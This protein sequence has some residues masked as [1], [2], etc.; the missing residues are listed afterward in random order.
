[1]AFILFIVFLALKLTKTIDWS[2]VWVTSP[3]WIS[4]ITYCAILI[5]YLIFLLL[6]GG[7]AMA[8]AC[9]GF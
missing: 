5:L 8:F 6:A 2:W 3:L 1:M 9:C 4:F 7:L